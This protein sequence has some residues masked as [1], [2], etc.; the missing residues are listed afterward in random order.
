MVVF[1]LQADEDGRKHCS[2]PLELC[3]CSISAS[4]S[5]DWKQNRCARILK[6]LHPTTDMTVKPRPLED[7][8]PF[9]TAPLPSSLDHADAR[10]RR[11]HLRTPRAPQR[12]RSLASPSMRTRALASEWNDFPRRL[13]LSLLGDTIPASRSRMCDDPTRSQCSVITPSS[14][15]G[16]STSMRTSTASVSPPPPTAPHL[17]HFLFLC[18]ASLGPG[19]S[20]RS[21]R[22]LASCL[23]A[24]SRR[25]RVGGDGS[26]L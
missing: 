16:T 13:R 9:P 20:P 14:A 18:P 2:P 1:I 5:F 4:P 15:R 8:R 7:K 24:G 21:L 23:P 11:T 10:E 26:Y 19:T 6:C 17:R 3:L 25:A 12:S 22:R